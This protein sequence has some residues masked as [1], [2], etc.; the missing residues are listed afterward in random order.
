M[1]VDFLS[2]LRAILDSFRHFS[3]KFAGKKEKERGRKGE[4]KGRKE[5]KKRKKKRG[6]VDEGSGTPESM[7]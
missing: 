5:G 1:C 3:T 4:K 6:E 7:F 2:I